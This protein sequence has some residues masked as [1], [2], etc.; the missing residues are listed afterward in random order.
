MKIDLRH[1]LHWPPQPTTI[2][3]VAIIGV[4]LF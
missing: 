1:V 4:G 2:A 3:G